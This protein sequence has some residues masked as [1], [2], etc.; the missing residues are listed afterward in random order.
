MPED[1]PTQDLTNNDQP[2]GDLTSDEKLDLILGRLSALENKVEERFKDTR[3]IW[4]QALAEI[5]EVKERVEI[6][7]T[8]L[9]AMNDDILAL[10][11]AERRLTGRI[12]K[13][14]GERA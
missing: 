10:R 1:D 14:E 13:L 4:E 7:D 5:L 2:T 12:T 3:P 6:I 9:S 8:K 11:A